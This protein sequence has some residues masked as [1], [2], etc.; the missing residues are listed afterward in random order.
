MTDLE[1]VN[2]F[3]A[4][5]DLEKTEQILKQKCFDI[6]ARLNEARVAFKELSEQHA[7][8][9]NEVV[10]LSQQLD[11]VLQVILELVKQEEESSLEATVVEPA[12]PGE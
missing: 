11:G 2:Q 7:T 3:L 6:D 10:G 1:L 5:E 12:V 4:R 9:Q 8:K